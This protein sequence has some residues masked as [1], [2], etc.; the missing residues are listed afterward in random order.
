MLLNFYQNSL[1]LYVG[2]ISKFLT[3]E[4]NLNICFKIHKIFFMNFLPIITT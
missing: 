3:L 2:I 1:I 4:N